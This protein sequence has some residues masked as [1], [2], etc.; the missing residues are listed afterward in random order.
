MSF[1]ANF[2]QILDDKLKETTASPRPISATFHSE[3]PLDPSHLAYLM[4]HV[5]RLN[6]T[7]IC[8]KYPMS[9]V[10]PQRKPHDLT[11]LQRQAFEFLK[12]R[13]ADLSEAFTERE[14][15]KAFRLAAMILHPDQGGNA[16]DFLA[17]KENLAILMDVLKK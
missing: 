5:N 3:G 4:G 11:T 1:Q 8:G 15:K 13:I 2:K 17:L 10:R 12:T 6:N 9:K 14:L 16:R 7:R